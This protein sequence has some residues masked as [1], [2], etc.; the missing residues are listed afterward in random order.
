MSILFCLDNISATAEEM[1]ES[2]NMKCKKKNE[3]IGTSNFVKR[4]LL[5]TKL[6]SNHQDNFII[7][8]LKAAKRV[9]PRFLYHLEAYSACSISENF[10]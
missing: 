1:R 8:S 5:L 7:F 6:F 3:M 9:V 2:K 4:K 10:N